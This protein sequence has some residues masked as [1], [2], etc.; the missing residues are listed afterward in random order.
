MDLR[1]NALLGSGGTF[2]GQGLV[3]GS[4]VIVGVAL[5]AT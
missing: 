5:R 1:L 3:A 4:E 2:Q